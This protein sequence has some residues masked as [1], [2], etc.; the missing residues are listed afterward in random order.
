VFLGGTIDVVA[1][2]EI[3]LTP[4]SAAGIISVTG[5]LT[6]RPNSDLVP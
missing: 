5:W 3:V 6:G 2:P 4:S 1:D